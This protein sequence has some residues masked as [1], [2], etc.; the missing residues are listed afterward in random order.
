MRIIM[1]FPREMDP[2]DRNLARDKISSAALPF[3]QKRDEEL[4]VEFGT[5]RQDECMLVTV[6][7]HTYSGDGLHQ[8]IGTTLASQCSDFTCKVAHGRPDNILYPR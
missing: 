6:T 4:V 7:E 3:M 8:S 2:A 5:M 1:D